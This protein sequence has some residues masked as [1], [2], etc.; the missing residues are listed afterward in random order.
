M[1]T[2][3]GVNHPAGG[4]AWA[5]TPAAPRHP[6][7]HSTNPSHRMVTRHSRVFLELP[8]TWDPGTP[9]LESHNPLQSGP[10]QKP[11]DPH[12]D[13][14]VCTGLREPGQLQPWHSLPTKKGHPLLGGSQGVLL[15]T[16]GTLESVAAD[17]D[18]SLLLPR[19][20][21]SSPRSLPCEVKGVDE[22][23]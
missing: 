18:Y 3:E 8:P 2:Q 19:A 1:A 10:F 17:H 13:L 23:A 16:P 12:Q 9:T 22:P 20:R 15:G 21:P 14:E 6:D 4:E 7:A 11:E 5:T